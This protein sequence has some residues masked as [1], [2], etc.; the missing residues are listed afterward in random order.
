LEAAHIEPLP[1]QLIEGI[2]LFAASV[3]RPADT[4]RLAA[5]AS[6]AR[7]TIGYRWYW[8]ADRTALAAALS[9]ARDRLDDLAAEH[10]GVAGRALPLADAAALAVRGAGTRTRVRSGWDALTGT[11]RDVITMVA[12]GASNDEIAVRLLI[13]RATVR[14][15]LNHVYTKL[16]LPNRAALAAAA[17]RRDDFLDRP[18]GRSPET[19]S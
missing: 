3:D 6:T 11:E 13:G 7:D 12:A 14:T 16:G 10:Q 4:I 18:R 5:A 15:H 17:A 9:R 2:E 1:I 8:P 19:K